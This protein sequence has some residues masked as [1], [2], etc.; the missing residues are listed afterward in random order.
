MRNFYF[1]FFFLF[2]S[3]AIL[4]QSAS[5][6][7][8]DENGDLLI[9]ASIIIKGTSVG[10][11][12]N[13]EGNFDLTYNGDFPFTIVVSYAGFTAQEILIIQTTNNLSIQLEEGFV[14]GQEVVISAS[15]RAEKLQEAPAAV[16]VISGKDIAASGGAISPIRAL[17]NTPGVELQ[18]QTGQR[19]NLALRGSSGVFSTDVFP[20]LDYR[21]LIS[22]GVEFFD[23][24]NS[25]LNNIDIERI[26]VVLGPGS[27]LYGPDV[28]SG[29]VHFISKDPFRH[30]GTTVELIYGEMNT[31]KTA[32]RHAG[33]NKEANFG[34]KIN[35]RYGSGDDF[36]LD[37]E[38]EDDA[39]VLT[40][41]VTIQQ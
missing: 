28:T 33:H 20:M 27:A 18:Q 26:E 23:S 8:S 10:T 21:S 3:T 17:I 41:F 31:F 1:L 16:S 22:P 9:G 24:Q 6:T 29:V 30:P 14:F 4:A 37:P 25:P 39:K 32:I 11:T 19:I 13:M 34:Y 2:S 12:T 7:V 38:D 15:R 35:A 5:G 36:V 40:N